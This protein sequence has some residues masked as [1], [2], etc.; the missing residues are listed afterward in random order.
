MEDLRRARV[1]AW[2]EAD[3]EDPSGDLDPQTMD[4]P[5]LE[6]YPSAKAA[7]TPTL[8]D[9][10]SESGAVSKER[11]DSHP[12]HSMANHGKNG[13]S[14]FNSNSNSNSNSHSHWNTKKDGTFLSRTEAPAQKSTYVPPFGAKGDSC[15]LEKKELFLRK[16][17]RDSPLRMLM[18]EVEERLEA[19]FTEASKKEFGELYI[20]LGEELIR[21]ALEKAETGCRTYWPYMRGI[22]K[23]L[24]E[25]GVGSRLEAEAYDRSIRYGGDRPN[26][27]LAAELTRIKEENL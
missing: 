10:V 13:Y 7:F 4:M 16:S 5:M 1:L 22:L 26:A 23:N 19:P 9:P 8:R 3:S 15:V 12:R 14:N 6:T 27:Y 17:H 18:T 20:A 11:T 2:L 24:Q 21:Y 25:R